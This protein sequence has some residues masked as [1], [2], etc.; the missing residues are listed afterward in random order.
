MAKWA[1]N[2]VLDAFLD[3]LIDN[4]SRLCICS[5]QPTTYTE[6]TSTYLIGHADLASGD[7]SGPVDGDVSG[8]KITVGA[9]L[10]LSVENAGTAKHWCLVDVS[11][12]KLLYV[13]ICAAKELSVGDTFDTPD[14]DIEIRD[15]L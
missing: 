13:G 1:H 7:I 11:N 5:E 15:P 9:A 2:D 14:W 10:G 12:T 8:R 6:A 4:A 3:Y